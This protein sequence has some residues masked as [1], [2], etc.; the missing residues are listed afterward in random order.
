MYFNPTYSQLSRR[1]LQ[2]RPMALISKEG[3]RWPKDV[4]RIFCT[5]RRITDN[6]VEPAH[7]SIIAAPSH[8]QRRRPRA[9]PQLSRQFRVRGPIRQ[10]RLRQHQR[11]RIPPPDEQ[12]Q[13]SERWPAR[14][15]PSNLISAARTSPMHHPGWLQRAPPSTSSTPQSGRSHQLGLRA[16][17]RAARSARP[18]PPTPRIAPASQRCGPTSPRQHPEAIIHRPRTAGVVPIRIPPTHAGGASNLIRELAAVQPCGSPAAPG[19]SAVSESPRR[20]FAHRGHLTILGDH[21]PGQRPEFRRESAWRESPSINMRPCAA[22]TASGTAS[23][24]VGPRWHFHPISVR[25]D[26]AVP[27]R[28]RSGCGMSRKIRPLCIADAATS[29]SLPLGSVHIGDA[30]WR[31]SIRSA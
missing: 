3:R 20:L 21:T 5:E 18:T 13:R 23:T 7:H 25:T 24:G 31:R 19:Q 14:V 1:R 28:N 10:V 22:R 12:E 2:N 6:P 17:P 16:R 11:P 27:S 30:T 15:P 9:V 4:R 8:P 29:A 26:G